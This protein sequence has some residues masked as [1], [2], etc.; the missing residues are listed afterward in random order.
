MPR[1]RKKPAPLPDWAVN[2]FPAQGLDENTS[3]RRRAVKIIESIDQPP[4]DNTAELLGTVWPAFKANHQD[5]ITR[6]TTKDAILA[7]EE[8]KVISDPYEPQTKP[9]IVPVETKPP[10][11]NRAN[12]LNAIG[13]GKTRLHANGRPRHHS[14][15]GNAL[16]GTGSRRTRHNALA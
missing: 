14:S 8:G 12:T 4:Q 9:R 5:L 3:N 2:P 15:G 16:H 7:A 13:T 1:P 10:K 6:I 11:A